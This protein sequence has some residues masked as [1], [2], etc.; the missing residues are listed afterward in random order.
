MGSISSVIPA[1][2]KRGDL[3]VCD[4]A[5]NY[6]IQ[7]GMLL[8]RSI[9]KYYKHNDMQDLERVLA[10]AVQEHQ[11]SGKKLNRRFIVTEGISAYYGDI[12]P[13]DK[14]VQ[15]RHKYKFR[16]IL[17]DSLAVGVLGKNGRGS[18]E[19]FD[20]KMEDVELLCG[21]LDAALGS[22]GGFCVSAWEFTIDHQRLT[23]AGYVFSATSPPYTAAAGSKALELIDKNPQLCQQ[24]RQ[25]STY[26]HSLLSNL[27]NIQLSNSLGSPLFY[28]RLARSYGSTTVDSDIMDQVIMKLL[29]T[30]ISALNVDGV[31]CTAPDYV[32][33]ER[34]TPP[35]AIRLVVCLHHTEQDLQLAAEAIQTTFEQ[36]L[37]SRK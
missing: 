4:E 8:S 32:P 31:A 26:M 37:S 19:E 2:C 13:L 10:T 23:S 30:P 25:K 1:Y 21:T 34:R 16:I 6:G 22:V 20:V 17:D 5:V 28:I 15:L 24:L 29:Q 7:Q 33:F 12:A 35:P 9:I 27:S 11:K 14:I 36:V 3:I 18:I